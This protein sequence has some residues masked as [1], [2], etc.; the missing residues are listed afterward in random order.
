MSKFV[1]LL[2]GNDAK[3]FF[4]HLLLIFLFVLTI[5]LLFFWVY[6]PATTNHGDTVYLPDLRGKSLE[7]AGEEL[8]DLKLKYTLYDSSAQ[9]YTPE[10]PPFTVLDQSPGAGEKVKEKRTIYLTINPVNPPLVNLPN[11]TDISVRN[12]LILLKNAGLNPGEIQYVDDIVPNTVLGVFVDGVEISNEQ[13]EIGYKV[14]KGTDIGLE[15]GNGR[16]SFLV[17]IPDVEGIDFRMGERQLISAG[18]KVGKITLV[19][20]DSLEANTI[21]S[22][23][24]RPTSSRISNVGAPVRLTVVSSPEMEAEVKEREEAEANQ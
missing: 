4:F 19:E 3:G 24:P 20:V 2:K 7:Q 22:Q 21:V 5:I 8:R 1:S 6:L 17:S 9:M 14:Y 23:N 15:V 12:A 18:L 13:L 10:Y 16:R 11:I